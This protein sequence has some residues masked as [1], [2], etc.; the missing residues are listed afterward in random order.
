MLSLQEEEQKSN[1]KCDRI[2]L[3]TQECKGLFCV[4]TKSL[5]TNLYESESIAIHVFETESAATHF[6]WASCY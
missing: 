4:E 5:A 1:R 3:I 6:F 2:I